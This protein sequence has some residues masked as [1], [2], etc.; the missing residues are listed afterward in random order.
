MTLSEKEGDRLKVLHEVKQ[1]HLTQSQAAEQVG[2]SERGF[3]KLLKRFRKNKDSPVTHGL[4]GKRSNR[5]LRE[6]TAS[7]AV[8]AVRQ[9][10]RDFGPTLAAEY[11]DKDLQISLSRETLRQLRTLEGK[12]AEDQR[13]TRVAAPAQLPGR[14]GAVGYQRACLTGRAGTRQDVSDRADR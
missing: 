5:G 6:E 12:D 1:G 8:Q 9:G 3:R 13:G 7:R 14:T 4:R 11:L 10:Y 2:M